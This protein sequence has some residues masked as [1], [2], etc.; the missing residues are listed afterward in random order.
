MAEKRKA[1]KRSSVTVE[2]RETLPYRIASLLRLVA[3]VPNFEGFDQQIYTTHASL[4]ERLRRDIE[5]IYPKL[6]EPLLLTR[7]RDESPG[8]DDFASLIGW[9]TQIPPG[10]IRKSIALSIEELDGAETSCAE[11]ADS[12]LEVPPLDDASG[13]RAFLQAVPDPWAERVREDPEVLEQMLRFLQD[14][15]ELKARLV[16]MLTRFWDGYGRSLDDACTPIISRSLRYHRQREYRGD[17]SDVYHE[18]TGKRP[19]SNETRL[20]F[21]KAKHVIFVPSCHSGPYASIACP[22]GDE[23]TL[24][25]VFNCRS[26]SGG[27]GSEPAIVGRVFPPLK[28]LADETRLQIVHLLRDRE[29]YAQ[30]IVDQLDLSQ[31]TVSRHL[32]L[33]V[34]CGVLTVRK[35]NGMK[36]YTINESSME[37]FIGD[38]QAL[39]RKGGSD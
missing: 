10:E 32:S 28:G 13:L 12:N 38:L 34:A 23:S 7:L 26:S 31:S 35:G 2:F 15:E 25:V 8:F 9:L 17:G 20:K 14:P 4:P 21:D 19:S 6:A 1:E 3:E 33:L 27:A 5:L 37:R 29:L 22:N 16:L 11:A 39:M 24:I 18:V 30:Q 36:F